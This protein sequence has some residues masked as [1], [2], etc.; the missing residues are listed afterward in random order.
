VS[1]DATDETHHV[2][3]FSLSVAPEQAWRTLRLAVSELPR[4]KIVADTEA[5]LHAECRS[6]VFGFVDDL[7][8]HLRGD[9]GQVAVRSA[10]R[11]GYSDFGVNRGRVERLR[12]TLVSA[13]VVKP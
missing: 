9:E 5:Y 13:G 7:E 12:R 10:A 1:S 8:L 3:P 6:A 11:L 4:T 2:A